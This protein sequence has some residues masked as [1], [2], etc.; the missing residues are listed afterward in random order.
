MVK[1]T[2]E[3]YKK[4]RKSEKTKK[5][6]KGLTLL[7]LSTLFFSTASFSQRTD[8]EFNITDYDIDE[9]VHDCKDKIWAYASIPLLLFSLIAGKIIR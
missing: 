4:I 1:V 7:L 9:A 3:K 5:I 6:R 2:P 8:D